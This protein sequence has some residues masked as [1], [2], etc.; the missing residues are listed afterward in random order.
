M[1]LRGLRRVQAPHVQTQIGSL[2]CITSKAT[3]TLSRELNSDVSLHCSAAVGLKTSS[4]VKE[5]NKYIQKEFKEKITFLVCLHIVFN[6]ILCF[7]ISSGVCT[8]KLTEYDP[9]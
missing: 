7:F 9:I 4:H 6:I 5:T 3:K 2:Y 1:G 8:K